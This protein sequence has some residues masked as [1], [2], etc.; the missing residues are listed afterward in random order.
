MASVVR[1]AVLIDTGPIVAILSARDAQHD[2]CVEQLRAMRAPLVTTWPVLTEAI[3]LLPR[4]PTAVRALLAAV[5]EASWLRVARL[6]EDAASWFSTFFE[7]YSD[8]E[9]QLADASLV[10]LAER[11]R[12]KRVFTLDRRNFAM[13]R[14]G[15]GRA[16]GIVP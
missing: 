5:I 13:Y 15:D 4:S 7:R 6:P 1:N 14:T 2:A 3:Y 9:A 10:Y 8:H 11:R 16:L 12:V